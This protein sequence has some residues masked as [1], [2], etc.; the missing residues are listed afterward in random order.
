MGLSNLFINNAA[1]LRQ[2]FWRV[3]AW[4]RAQFAAGQRF[5]GEPA[6]PVAATKPLRRKRLLICAAIFVTAVGVRLLHWQDLHAEIEQGDTLLS[7]L[8]KDYQHNVRQMM[9]ESALL[10]V[11]ASEEPEDARI[12]EHPPGYSILLLGLYRL[13]G[14]PSVRLRLLQVLCDAAAAVLIFLIAAEML[15][16]TVGFIAGLLVAL[17]PHLAYYSLWLTPD[18]LAVL[19]VVL[20]TYLL[21]RAI[22]SPRLS[23]LL[24]AGA[25]LGISCWLRANGLLLVPFFLIPIIL[26]F[27]RGRRLRYAGGL[28]VAMLLVIAPITIRNWAVFQR[29]IPL[30]L[31]AGITLIEGIADYDDEGQFVFK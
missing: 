26:L 6:P 14:D 1:L 8:L 21:V 9:D 28:A 25:A 20:A 15:P 2:G 19:P 16:V 18:S 17:S 4:M 29:Y 27:P 23:L 3:S 31:G 13:P 22:R 7:D 10:F 5:D 12:L 24:A 11:H 30:S